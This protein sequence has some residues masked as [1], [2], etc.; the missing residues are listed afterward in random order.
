M[1]AN[2]A[3]FSVDQTSA[4]SSCVPDLVRSAADRQGHVAGV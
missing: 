2:G 3:P 1:K 4:T